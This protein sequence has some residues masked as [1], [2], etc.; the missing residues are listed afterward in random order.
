MSDRRERIPASEIPDPQRWQLP[1][2][3]EPSHE[4]RAQM[5]QEEKDRAAAAGEVLVE[6]D[7][8]EVEPLTA[9]Q[10]EEIRQEAYDAGLEEGLKEGREKGEK[11]GHE[12][13]HEKGL[14]EGQI[15][16]RKLGF[17]AGFEKGESKALAKGEEE[18]AKTN[19]TLNSTINELAHELKQHKHILEDNLPLLVTSLAQAVIA[20]ELSQGSEHIVNLVKLALD[21]FPMESGQI[22]IHVNPQDLPFLEAAFENTDLAKSLMSEDNM[23]AGGCRLS[24]RYS[25]VDFTLDSRWQNILKQY[26]K[27]LAMGLNDVENLPEP[28]TAFDR[29]S[30]ASP[31]ANSEESSEESSEEK[32]ESHAQTEAENPTETN[33][34]R[35][36]ATATPENIEA[37]AEAETSADATLESEAASQAETETASV[38]DETQTDEAQIETETEA[39]TQTDKNTDEPET[40]TQ[41]PDNEEPT[42]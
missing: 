24:S 27:Q 40:P 19:G 20:A 22:N 42:S 4:V 23:E 41:A 29:D 9:E 12:A 39:Q 5:E 37:E 34:D 11:E 13:G 8:I 16:G 10:L 38:I 28:Q 36:Q 33:D 3:G 2:W 31:K 17:D 35:E 7:E 14:N 21:A 1:S 18:I 26:N 15:E 32:V 6:E 25:A 30:P